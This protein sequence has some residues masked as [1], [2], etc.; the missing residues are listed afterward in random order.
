MDMLLESM[1]AE[2][3]PYGGQIVFAW[4]LLFNN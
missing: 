3:G 2:L 1:Y 4:L